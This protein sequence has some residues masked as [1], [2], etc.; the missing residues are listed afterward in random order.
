MENFIGNGAPRQLGLFGSGVNDI[1]GEK[2]QT[3]AREAELDNV[4]NPKDSWQNEPEISDIERYILES[5][6]RPAP[7]PKKGISINILHT[8]DLHG[9][10][11]PQQVASDSTVDI[12]GGLRGGEGAIASVIKK[13]RE[14]SKEQGAHF[15]LLDAG[16]MAMGSP[17]SGMFKGEPVIEVMNREGYDAATVGNHDF[18]WGAEPLMNMIQKATFPFVSANILDQEGKPLPK[19]SPF[20][21]KDLGDVKVGIVG[22]ITDDTP[23]IT[24][25]DEVKKMKFADPVETLKT[26]IPKMKQDGAEI[27]VVLSHAGL[28]ADKKIAG[29]VD[30]IDVI[31][32]GH[33]HDTIHDPFLVSGTLIAQ[34]GC[35][36]KNIGK[37]RL[38]WSPEEKKV[39]STGGGLIPIISD[40]INPDREIQGIIAKYQKKVD[41]LMNVKLGEVQDNLQQP[42]SGNET[43]LGNFITDVM[44]E[45]TGAQVAL[46]NSGCIRADLVKGEVNYKDIYNMLPFDSKIVTL[47]MKGDDILKTL[48]QSAGREKDKRLQVSGLQV[49]CDSSQPEGNRLLEVKLANGENLDTRKTYTVATIDYLSQGGDHYEAFK[50]GNPVGETKGILMDELAETVAQSRVLYSPTVGRIT[51]LGY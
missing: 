43:N 44:R 9:S 24:S 20:V 28:D 26:T 18:D 4:I 42:S 17:I 33:S 21:I 19:V 50:K 39:T 23:R 36:G 8:N 37:L 40:Q 13:E 35:G 16:D 25:R 30:G 5:Q 11:L 48:E 12:G 29:Q 45:R 1:S 49:I 10:L 27:I 47:E 38:Q 51:D 14:T 2:K 22:V 34:A 6:A 15:L 3:G 32:G 31:I 7:A 41:S 46:L